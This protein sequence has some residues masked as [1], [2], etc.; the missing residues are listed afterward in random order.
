MIT[1][2][3]LPPPHVMITTVTTTL[4]HPQTEW[5]KERVGPDSVFLKRQ[6]SYICRGFITAKKVLPEFLSFLAGGTIWLYADFQGP[7]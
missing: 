7:I 2:W 1:K 6:S 4:L 3:F 5:S